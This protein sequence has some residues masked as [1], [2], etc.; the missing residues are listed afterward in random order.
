MCLHASTHLIQE[1]PCVLQKEGTNTY[2]W[3]LSFVLGEG[4][5]YGVAL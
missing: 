5:H 2:N 1:V 3:D 4:V